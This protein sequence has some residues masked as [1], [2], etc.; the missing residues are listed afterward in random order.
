MFDFRHISPFV[1]ESEPSATSPPRGVLAGLGF[2]RG[3]H[4]VAPPLDLPLAAKQATFLVGKN[5]AGKTSMLLGLAGFLPPTTSPNQSPNRSPI[6]APQGANRG[7]TPPLTPPSQ[8]RLGG[9]A[10]PA[11]RDTKTPTQ[12][13]RSEGKIHLQEQDP[14]PRSTR[15]ENCST[16]G[17]GQKNES[18]AHPLA[19]WMQTPPLFLPDAQKFPAGL[20]VRRILHLQALLAGAGQ[21]AP[22]RAQTAA[23]F[24]SLPLDAQAIQL[25]AGQ[26]RRLALAPLTFAETAPLWLLDEPFAHLDPQ[27]VAG[28]SQCLVRH[29]EAG[30]VAVLTQPTL[31]PAV[32]AEQKHTPEAKS[33]DP[34]KNPLT[35]LAVPVSH[36]SLGTEQATPDL[37]KSL[38]ADRVGKP[39]GLPCI[40]PRRRWLG[41][42]LADLRAGGQATATAATSLFLVAA[43]FL[44][45]LAAGGLDFSAASPTQTT[46]LAPALV[47]V[48]CLL[49]VCLTL[50]TPWHRTPLPLTVLLL[51]LPRST[52]VLI[53]TATHFFLIFPPLVVGVAVVFVLLGLP[54][55]A[56][57]ASL[58]GLAVLSLTLASLACMTACLLLAARNNGLL[59]GFVFL[60][61]AVAPLLAFAALLEAALFPAQSA[62]ALIP[63]F[64]LSTGLAAVFVPSCLAAAV[65]ALKGAVA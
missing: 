47:S 38:G 26:Q 6:S 56:L 53:R 30:G 41:L 25:S 19:H 43:G 4:A 36:F 40:F 31:P 46:A 7:F 27:A 9:A 52:L 50:E 58:G 2:L 3:G 20:S 28:V 14:D 42:L 37:Q 5:G 16:G 63:A 65:V 35:A 55:T 51:A 8:D 62:L 57:L 54:L 13:H 48:L 49:A 21:A 59:L 23:E 17:I 33:Q 1:Q 15:A 10:T 18:L 12:E 64:G 60:P 34:T 39:F 45:G 61:L 44:F 32:L 22:L 29:L 24:F 11:P